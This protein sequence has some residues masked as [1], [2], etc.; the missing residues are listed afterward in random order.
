M[1]DNI[2]IICGDPYRF[3]SKI[4]LSN[5]KIL[6]RET[7]SGETYWDRVAAVIK[8]S[9]MPEESINVP[10]GISSYNR[11]MKAERAWSIPYRIK[12][13]IGSFNID[14]LAAVSLDEY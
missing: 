3:H 12:S 9:I 10:S 2:L 14:D 1:N 4:T 11:Q 8:N 6:I 13:I 7:G 5:M